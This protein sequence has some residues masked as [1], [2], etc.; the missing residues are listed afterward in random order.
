MLVGCGWR[1]SIFLFARLQANV[2]DS[3]DRSGAAWLRSSPF[4]RIVKHK[5]DTPTTL[6]RKSNIKSAHI[7]TAKLWELCPSARKQHLVLLHPLS[8]C[9][10]RLRQMRIFKSNVKFYGQRRNHQWLQRV[11]LNVCLHPSVRPSFQ[12]IATVAQWRTEDE[13]IRC[14]FR[15]DFHTWSAA[16]V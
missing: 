9:R 2:G 8:T 10:R 7:D 15:S 12:D 3:C 14:T 5:Q 16:S 4:N 1:S 6:I 13:E 11:A